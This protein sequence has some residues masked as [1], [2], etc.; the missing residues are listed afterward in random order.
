MI[1][2]GKMQ[3]ERSTT[4]TLMLPHR[5]AITLPPN[6]PA[7]VGRYP[8]RS[9]LACS[10]ISRARCSTA[11]AL[12]LASKFRRDRRHVGSGCAWRR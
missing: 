12:R 4:D 2:D 6:H 11:Q 5:Q 8:Q 1:V 3:D 10:H 7:R 9:S